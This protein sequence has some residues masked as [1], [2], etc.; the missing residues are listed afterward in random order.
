MIFLKGCLYAHYYCYLVY[1]LLLYLPECFIKINTNGQLLLRFSIKPYEESNRQKKAGR[2]RGK[3]LGKIYFPPKPLQLH[4]F[5]VT[6]LN[7]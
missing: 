6:P 1:L 3:P 5:Q 7:I 4:V 2:K